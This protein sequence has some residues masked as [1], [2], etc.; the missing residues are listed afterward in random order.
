MVKS[1]CGKNYQKNG[2]HISFNKKVN[3]TFY[4]A[5]DKPSNLEENILLKEKQLQNGKLQQLCKR[6]CNTDINEVFNN[7]SSKIPTDSSSVRSPLSGPEYVLINEERN[8]D[9]DNQC[10]ND[11]YIN[12]PSETFEELTDLDDETLENLSPPTSNKSINDLS[13]TEFLQLFQWD[14]IA[15]ETE[16]AKWQNL[17]LDYRDR[18]ALNLY[19]LELTPSHVMTIPTQLDSKPAF[20][21][22]YPFSKTAETFLK[23]EIQT[24]KD[25]K[26]LEPCQ[27]EYNSPLHVVPKKNKTELRMVSD[28]R[29]LNEAVIFKRFSAIKTDEILQRL[30]NCSYFSTLDL[31]TAYYQIPLAQEDRHKTALEVLG[32]KLQYTVCPMGVKNASAN[33]QYFM[34]N[35]VFSSLANKVHAIADDS[36]AGSLQ[37]QE[38][39]NTVKSMLDQLRKHNLK[40]RPDKCIF[41]A[42]TLNFLGHKISKNGISTEDEKIEAIKSYPIPK[43]RKHV[44]RFLG[45]CNFYSK[46]IHNFAEKAAPLYN[47]TSKK[48]KFIWSNQAQ[49]SFN[50]LKNALISKP[51]LHYIDH[52]KEFYLECDASQYAVGAVLLQEGEDNKLFPVAYISKKLTKPQLKWSTTEKEMYS[53]YYCLSQAEK[54]V[55]G[56]KLNIRTDHKPLIGIFQNKCIPKDPTGKMARYLSYIQKFHFELSFKPGKTNI[57]ADDLSR[58]EPYESTNVVQ[59][60]TK[61]RLNNQPHSNSTK[62]EKSN[63]SNF[64]WPS[65]EDIKSWQSNDPFCCNLFNN[66]R[67]NEPINPKF[68]NIN[69]TKFRLI[70]NLLYFINKNR[71]QLL[72]IPENESLMFLKQLHCENGHC[73]IDNLKTIFSETYYTTRLYTLCKDTIQKCSICAQFRGTKT[74]TPPLKPL[75]VPDR[76]FKTWSIDFMGPLTKSNK[77]NK[78][79]FIAVCNLS[80]WVEAYH[81]IDM[82]AETVVDI[83]FKQIIPR[84]GVP[85]N[86]VSDRGSNFLSNT[87]KLLYA[88]LKINKSTSAPYSPKS[89]GLAEAHVKMVKQNLE[90]M[91]QKEP[92]EWDE[93]LNLVLG[94]LRCVPHHSHGQ[95][96][97]FIAYGQDPVRPWD[98]L[99]QSKAPNYLLGYSSEGLVHLNIEKMIE[100]EKNVYD[101]LS[102][103]K[104][105]MKVKHDTKVYQKKLTIGQCI[106]LKNNQRTSLQP[107]WIKPSRTLEITA[108]S[109]KIQDMKSLKK[110]WVNRSQIKQ[111]TDSQAYDILSKKCLTNVQNESSINDSELVNMTTVLQ[112]GKTGLLPRTAITCNHEV[113][114]VIFDT[115]A[116]CSVI[117]TNASKLLQNQIISM[118]N[119]DSKL[120]GAGNNS[121]ATTGY[122][123][124]LEISIQ[125][126]KFRGCFLEV[127]SNQTT[128]PLILIGNDFLRSCGTIKFHY[129]ND[130]VILSLSDI[131]HTIMLNLK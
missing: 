24:L 16:K 32:E 113:I 87:M 100:V 49:E 117:N 48:N 12:N 64:H 59:T 122:K 115:G 65:I 95:S 107:K 20:R 14:H 91:V 104:Q 22:Q 72:I 60:R 41:G 63:E 98:T 102:R 96:P 93:Y 1:C 99:I 28:F 83:F 92:M 116:S 101:T 112:Y 131:D 52:N 77:G 126:L 71:T 66:I 30:S 42:Q 18:F 97:F 123:L 114:D 39:F 89:N 45:T 5:N 127:Q 13:D 55:L 129:N 70:N 75:E 81:T 69:I 26:I 67:N 120:K 110:Y 40:C 58:T 4:D 19:D 36:I 37:F 82:T 128:P 57:I 35:T 11:T 44:M 108:N 62:Q 51:I 3:V 8:T 106:L 84:F 33:L 31:K 86:I 2:K 25:C 29:Q 34:Q 94:S 46:F 90:R 125:N 54:W 118:V 10:D 68:K 119:S 15:N 85:E 6:S 76:K 109:L 47:L 80:K 50:I 124:E 38:N 88:K 121:I 111:I 53:I 9:N 17:I 23:T 21:K 74:E 105:E 103:H 61:N 7:V 27:S 78:Y 56:S 79:I 73:S 43:T 130:K